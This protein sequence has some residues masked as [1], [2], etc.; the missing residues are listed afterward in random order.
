ML[1]TM[2]YMTTKLNNA[3]LVNS[4]QIM[5]KL[6]NKYFNLN[7]IINLYLIDQSMISLIDYHSH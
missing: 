7:N 6:M 2:C 1:G 3:F 5:V 4:L